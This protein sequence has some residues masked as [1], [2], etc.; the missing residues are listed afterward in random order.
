MSLGVRSIAQIY[1]YSKLQELFISIS[2]SL[3]LYLF[4]SHTHTLSLSLNY[5][6]KCFFCEC[7]T[8]FF[9]NVRTPCICS[10]LLVISNL[11]LCNNFATVL[12]QGVHSSPHNIIHLYGTAKV[13]LVKQQLAVSYYESETKKCVDLINADMMI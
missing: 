1:Q 2:V 3:S 13:Q 8:L 10:N 7:E 4:L 11:N 6:L 5:L 9:G 12:C